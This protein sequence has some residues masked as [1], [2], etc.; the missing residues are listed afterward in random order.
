MV[1]IEETKRQR[2]SRETSK[3]DKLKNM[4]KMKGGA[5]IKDSDVKAAV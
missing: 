1:A 4:M 5:A 3:Y 2:E